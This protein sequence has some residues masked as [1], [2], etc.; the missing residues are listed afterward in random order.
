M[1]GARGVVEPLR[2]SP[3]LNVKEAPLLSRRGWRQVGEGGCVE[4]LGPGL[5]CLRVKMDVD[6]GCGMRLVRSRA[7]AI[8]A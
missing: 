6:V 7:R 1:E 4:G 2:F 3:A 8:S 5:S